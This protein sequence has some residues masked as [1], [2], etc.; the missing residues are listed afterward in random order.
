MGGL[1]ISTIPVL[2]IR[3]MFKYLAEMQLM[4]LMF[5]HV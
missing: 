5:P 3:Q 2:N 4:M 1:I